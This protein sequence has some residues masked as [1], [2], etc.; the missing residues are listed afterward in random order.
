MS[1]ALKHIGVRSESLHGAKA[2][3]ETRRPDV[4]DIDEHAS[5]EERAVAALRQIYDPEIPVNI[6]E[7]GLIYALDVDEKEGVIHLG[8]TLTAPACP[9]AQTFPGEIEARLR[10]L[11]GVEEVT[12]RLVWDPPWTQDRMT[13]AAKLQLGLL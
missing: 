8:M 5:L 7:L 4:S 9:V 3:G 13:E 2:Q 10:E 12:V 11:D 1:D 6:Y